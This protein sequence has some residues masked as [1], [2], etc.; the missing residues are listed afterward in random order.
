MTW[1]PF[2]PGG[3]IMQTREFRMKI[4]VPIIARAIP[5]RAPDD[6]LNLGW[7]IGERGKID[8]PRQRGGLSRR[9]A[10]QRKARV[11]QDSP[12]TK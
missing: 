6:V 2:I 3:G 4:R 11:K 8:N 10:W 5:N 12:A 9:H 1:N 7:P